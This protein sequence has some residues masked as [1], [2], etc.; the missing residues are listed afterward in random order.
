MNGLT[1]RQAEVLR[2]IRS[3]G[4]THGMAP[5]LREIGAAMGIG[6]TNGV[7]FHLQALERKGAIQKRNMLSR[8]ITVVGDR[9]RT[10]EGELDTSSFVVALRHACEEARRLIESETGAIPLG[11]ERLRVYNILA[12]V[13]TKQPTIA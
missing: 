13:L 9:E 11:G 8:S 2:F 6:S 3:Y 12:A 10:P 7:A 1:D 5:T 4:N